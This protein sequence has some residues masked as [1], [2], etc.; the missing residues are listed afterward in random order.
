MPNS[1]N[2][3][4][5]KGPIIKE[6][7]ATVNIANKSMENIAKTIVEYEKNKIDLGSIHI[8]GNKPELW[9]GDQLLSKNGF[10]IS[11]NKTRFFTIA[12]DAN[13]SAFD[14]AHPDDGHYTI[15]MDGRNAKLSV[16]DAS[17]DGNKSEILIGDHLLSKNGFAIIQSKSRFFTIAADANNSAFDIAHPDNGHYTIRMDGRNA[18]L[19]VGSVLIDGNAGDVILQNA[20]CAED[21]E[22]FEAE[23]VD[24]GTV[25]ALNNDGKLVQSKQQYDKRVAGVISGAGDLKPGLVLGRQLGN[26]NRVPLALVGRVNCKVDADY[27]SIDVGDLLTT[28]ETPGHAMKA[29]DPT[30]SFGAVIGKA[31]KPLKIGQD[32]IPILVALQ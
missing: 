21:F 32:L 4:S 25:M 19:S 26:K 20:D 5:V 11:Q 30:R 10:A 14:I 7:R 22:V 8:D 29:S 6:S 12:A 16:G 15:R 28:S 31:L 27:E 23:H 24:P 18:K 9:V 17:I 1:T 2:I 13:N 3:K